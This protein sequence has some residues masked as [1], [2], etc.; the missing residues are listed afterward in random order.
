MP[1]GSIFFGGEGCLFNQLQ[2]VEI[3]GFPGGSDG[4]ESACQCRRCKRHGF[5]PSGGEDPLEKEMGT[6]SSILAWRVLWIQE[7]SRLQ[8]IG[9]YRAGH[10]WSNLA[11]MHIKACIFCPNLGQLRR[12]I[13]ASKLTVGLGW[14]QVAH[15][16]DCGLTF[17]SVHSCFL[18]FPYTDIDPKGNS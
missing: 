8:S 1:S 13:L 12:V 18:F 3:T 11:L 14:A 7:P 5:H 17:L 16:L 9:L 15:G 2:Y 4:K 10:D 6:H